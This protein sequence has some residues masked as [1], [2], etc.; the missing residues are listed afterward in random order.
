MPVETLLLQPMRRGDLVGPQLLVAADWREPTWMC[1][2]LVMAMKREGYNE[3]QLGEFT[4]EIRPL[5]DPAHLHA[6]F[7][8]TKREA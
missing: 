3:D 1:D 5:T 8:A 2:H 6:T 4:M 7:A